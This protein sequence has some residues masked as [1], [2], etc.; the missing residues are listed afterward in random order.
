[1]GIFT[2]RILVYRRPLLY[3]LIAT[4]HGGEVGY[5]KLR[6]YKTKY[7]WVETG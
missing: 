7:E 4:S 2:I 1:M 3:D 5:R 6:L